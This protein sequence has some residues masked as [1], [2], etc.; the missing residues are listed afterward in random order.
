M[1]TQLRLKVWSRD[2][3]VTVST[4]STGL[5]FPVG[6]QILKTRN[7]YTEAFIHMDEGYRSLS[8][9]YTLA[10]LTEVNA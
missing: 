2:T 8:G 1:M 5:K 4:A 6:G 10:E 3:R 7:Q 9:W